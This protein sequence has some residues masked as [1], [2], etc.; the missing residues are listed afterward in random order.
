MAFSQRIQRCHRNATLSITTFT[1]LWILVFAL[2][3]VASSLSL[4]SLLVQRRT[5]VAAIVSAASFSDIQSSLTPAS[6]DQPQISIPDS[7]QQ[8]SLVE[9]LVSFADA[10]S[11]RPNPTDILFITGSTIDQADVVL[12]GAAVP[13]SRLSFPFRFQLSVKNALRNR[14]EEL[15]QAFK[16]QDIMVA[17]KVC[18]SNESMSGDRLTLL[19]TCQPSAQANGVAK[20]LRLQQGNVRAPVRLI[21]K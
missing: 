4:A 19:Q 14:K 9:G 6:P 15:V 13:V 20:L 21:L 2:A 12:A 5:F 10:L 17:V 3:P 16:K 18:A 7:L 11:M 8:Q 1:I